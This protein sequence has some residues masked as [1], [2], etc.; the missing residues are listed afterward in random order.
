[1][2][3]LNQCNFIGRLGKD[4]ELKAM[5]TGDAVVNFSLA[6]GWKSKNSEGVEWVTVVAFGKLAE[7]IGQHLQ[8]GSRVYIGGKQRT[9]KW[10]DKTGT[11][12]YTTEIVAR[13]MQMLGSK[14]D[15]QRPAAGN[16]SQQ[17]Q[18]PAPAG[19][20]PNEDIPF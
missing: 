18:A 15:A 3:D 4:P 17:F 7:I 16:A 2:N 14:A 1:M 8:K 6:C 12:R 13:D 19:D 11:D 9:R 5:P 20:V 10:Q